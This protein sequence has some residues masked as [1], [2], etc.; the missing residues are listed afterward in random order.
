[1]SDDSRPGGTLAWQYRHY[2]EFHGHRANLLLHILTVPVFQLGT[3][4]LFTGPLWGAW[5]YSLV[6]L[7]VMAGA[8]VAQGVGHA[9]ESNPPVPFAGPLDVAT[10]IVLEQWINFPRYVLS[11]GFSRAWKGQ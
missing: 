7:G 1:M 10:R 11:G 3:V 2:P 6:G 8:V 5:W 4:M 9:R